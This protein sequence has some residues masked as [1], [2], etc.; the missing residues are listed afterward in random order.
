MPKATRK[1]L[2]LLADLGLFDGVDVSS[3]EA[4][5]KIN[6]ALAKGVKRDLQAGSDAELSILQLL[7]QRELEECS[8]A[9][10]QRNSE[11]LDSITRKWDKE[12]ED[13][14]HDDEI[15]KEEDRRWDKV[16]KELDE[17][18]AKGTRETAETVFDN[19]EYFEGYELL[20]RKPSI[21]E[22]ISVFESFN[23]EVYLHMMSLSEDEGA[24][25]Q[26]IIGQLLLK[27]EHL[28]ADPINE[29]LTRHLTSDTKDI[30]LGKLVLLSLIGIVVI[31]ILYKITIGAPS[32]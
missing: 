26:F 16:L 6:E 20:S 8:S 13:W 3:D 11:K 23:S 30:K 31:V 5:G 15:I 32:H 18:S 12:I 29:L 22:I 17:E 21:D 27:F 14:K 24:L 28:R 4:I 7:K 9:S 25:H 1:Q 2:N 10:S 19:I